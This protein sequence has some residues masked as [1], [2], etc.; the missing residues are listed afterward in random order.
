MA[1]NDLK[2]SIMVEGK[3]VVTSSHIV[4]ETFL[5]TNQTIS[6]EIFILHIFGFQHTPS[7]LAQILWKEI[8]ETG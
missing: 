8:S 5:V 4:L 6:C 3:L 7:H 1:K 2:V